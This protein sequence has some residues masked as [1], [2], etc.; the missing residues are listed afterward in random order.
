MK[1]TAT[2][3]N[4]YKNN[5]VEVATEG[6]IKSL[7]IQSKSSG[8]GSA[9]NGGE[10]LFLALATCVCNDIYREAAK[11]QI[12]V[13][14]V[15]VKVTGEFGGEGDPG[16]NIVYEV[17]VISPTHGKEQI[18]ALIHCVDTIAEIHKTLRQGSAVELKL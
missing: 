3:S 11:R 9:V 2:I 1:I 18:D 7:S 17:S 4:Q 6:S 16:R 12:E 10:L 14:S 5:T 8:Y 13:S 15:D